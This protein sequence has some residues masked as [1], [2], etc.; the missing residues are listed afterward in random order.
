MKSTQMVTT[1][2]EKMKFTVT[3][4]H[5]HAAPVIDI[6]LVDGISFGFARVLSFGF[7]DMILW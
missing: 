4:C 7:V 6:T 1:P 3:I 2:N 5:R